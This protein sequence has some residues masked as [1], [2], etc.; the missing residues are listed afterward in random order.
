MTDLVM[1]TTRLHGKM[2]QLVITYVSLV[3][4][5]Y[6]LQSNSKKLKNASRKNVTLL[7]VLV[8]HQRREMNKSEW[9][10]DV[11]GGGNY[12]DA[13]MSFLGIC[14]EQLLQNVAQRVSKRVK[15]L[16]SPDHLM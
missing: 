6:H 4:S 3:I 2:G 5:Q 16:V 15:T 12:I 7:G 14:D 9:V 13:A 8:N 1:F 11:R 10:F